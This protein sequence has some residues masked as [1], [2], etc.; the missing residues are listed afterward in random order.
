MQRSNRSHREPSQ[1]EATACPSFKIGPPGFQAS[2]SAAGSATASNVGVLFLQQPD[3]KPVVDMFAMRQD[4]DEFMIPCKSS[5]V[6]DLHSM[7]I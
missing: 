1:E 3:G 5:R 6:V 4:E 2:S 7:N